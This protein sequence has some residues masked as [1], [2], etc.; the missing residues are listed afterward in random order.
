MKLQ[1]CQGPDHVVPHEPQ[2]GMG[3]NPVFQ[4]ET[5]KGFKQGTGQ[6]NVIGIL[7]RSQG[8]WCED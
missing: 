6:D 2:K 4:G 5:R 8:L 3:Y 7:E 1:S